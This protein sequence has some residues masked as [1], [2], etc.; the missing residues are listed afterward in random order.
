VLGW[1]NRA[2][3][4]G[5][6]LTLQ[7]KI[8]LCQQFARAGLH[9]TSSSLSNMVWYLASTPEQRDRLVDNPAG[10]NTS[11]T[12]RAKSDSIAQRTTISHSGWDG[13]SA[14]GCTWRERSSVSHGRRSTVGILITASPRAVARCG[15]RA[16]CARRTSY[17]S[18]S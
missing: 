11:S 12:M 16:R 15:T 1:L 7:E 5:R 13:T 6:P 17:G 9:T 8:R 14:S 4:D 2:E 3:V 10:M 18:I